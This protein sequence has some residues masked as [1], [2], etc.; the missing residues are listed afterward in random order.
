LVAYHKEKTKKYT[1]I[2]LQILSFYSNNDSHKTTIFVSYKNRQNSQK[3]PNSNKTKDLCLS[4]RIG[5]RLAKIDFDCFQSINKTKQI[6]VWTIMKNQKGFSLI[7]LLIVV[8]I[9]GIIAAVAIPNLLAARRSANEGSAIASLRTYH[10]A[11][12]TYAA[13]TG[14][15]E[16]AGTADGTDVVSFSTLSSNNLIDSVLGSGTKSGFEFKG[17]RKAGGTG[18]PAQFM[19]W[20]YPTTSTGV[21]QTGTKQFAIATEGVMYASTTGMVINMAATNI[22]IAGGSPLSN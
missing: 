13:T 7:E 3:T 5:T 15:G 20:A 6:G 9:I 17:G 19:G 11:Q 16:Y 14:S 4:N 10:G 1:A 18:V 2:Y 8:V 12:V 22:T 21:A